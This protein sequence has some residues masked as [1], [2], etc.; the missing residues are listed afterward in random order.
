M[1]KALLELGCQTSQALSQMPRK[2]GEDN[3]LFTPVTCTTLI[4]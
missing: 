2:N 3:E 1:V 4:G